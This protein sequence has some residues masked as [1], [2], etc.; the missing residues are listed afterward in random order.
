MRVTT[1]RPGEYF[2]ELGLMKKLPRTASAF[3]AAGTLI[4]SVD[5][6]AFNS[7]FRNNKTLISEYNLR[8]SPQDTSAQFLYMLHHAHTYNLFLAFLVKE[9]A[10]E[11][12]MFYRS[13]DHWE[14]IVNGYR[15]P[16][17]AM[18]T[19]AQSDRRIRMYDIA[20]VIGDLIDIAYRII[21][22]YIANDSKLQVC[23][24]LVNVL[25]M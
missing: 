20:P 16:F 9:V 12:I 25:L 1:I 8:E 23:M 18:G 13:V 22:R 14:D 15:I 11:S 17:Q 10:Q 3:A 4:M 21:E 6:M 24:D 19:G 2:G 5:G 7:F